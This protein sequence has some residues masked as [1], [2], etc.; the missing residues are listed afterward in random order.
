MPCLRVYDKRYVPKISNRTSYY[1]P[2]TYLCVETNLT[3]AVPY[4]KERQ[5]LN[6]NLVIEIV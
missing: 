4:W 5:R 1:R 6:P 2:P 3:W